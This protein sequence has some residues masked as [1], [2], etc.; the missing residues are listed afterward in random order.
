[1]VSL[2]EDRRRILLNTPHAEEVSD[3]IAS[4]ETDVPANLKKCVVEIDPIQDLHGYDYPWPGGGGK[5][6]CYDA[7]SELFCP[8]NG[9]S[10]YQ[11]QGSKTAYAK[12]TNNTNYVISFSSEPP[13]HSAFGFSEKPAVGV[14][15][16][17]I[18][19]TTVSATA[20]TFN[21]GDYDYIGFYYLQPG[22]T[23][24][25]G[26]VQIEQGTS[27][28]TFSPYSNICPISGRTGM[29]VERHGKNLLPN[30]LNQQ[31]STTVVLGQT[32]VFQTHTI[33][34]KAGT[35]TLTVNGTVN[36]SLYISSDNGLSSRI[37]T[38]PTVSFTLSEDDNISLRIYSDNGIDA[39][40]VSSFQLEEGSEATS[41]EPYTGETYDTTFPTEAGTVYGGTLDMLS[42][43]LT[44]DR[45][46][47]KISDLSWNYDTS[48]LRFNG[49]GIEEVCKKPESNSVT[50]P[51]LASSVYKASSAASTGSLAKNG[52]IGVLVSGVVCIRDESYSNVEEWLNFVGNEPIVYP[53]A[54]PITYQLDP[55]TLKAIRGTNNIWSDAGDTTVRFWTH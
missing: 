28:S 21:S 46:I 20:Y 12:V 39:S 33:S 43:V 30:K 10:I 35:Y 2:L 44:V 53:L 50:L 49:N 13:R 18:T 19:I 9:G 55:H 32:E 51:G 47:V 25:G 37:G 7:E 14:V 27:P 3:G 38:M 29:K 48:W 42:G 8:A 1:M 4:F 54:N 26:S 36:G 40:T 16:E 23:Y 45:A 31:T 22:G 15:G 41:Y 6:I 52:T 17:P 24:T 34:L 11:N 5:N